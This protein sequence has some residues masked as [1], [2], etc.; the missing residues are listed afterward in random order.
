[1]GRFKRAGGF[2][3]AQREV[4]LEKEVNSNLEGKQSHTGVSEPEREVSCTGVKGGRELT[5][6]VYIRGWIG[7]TPVTFTA[8]TGASR[9]VVSSRV[10][11][12]LSIKEKPVLKW[13]VKLRG[14]GGSPIHESGVGE[15]NMKL[16]PVKVTCQAVVADID[17]EVLLGPDVWAGEKD[18]QADIFL[19]KSIIK[20]KG[21]EI[22]LLPDTKRLRKVT[23]E[24]EVA[25]P[26]LSEVMADDYVEREEIDDKGKEENFVFESTDGFVQRNQLVMAPTLVSVNT[27]G[28]CKVNVLKPFSTGVALRHDAEVG[29]AERTDCC[30]AVIANE[31][32]ECERYN[33]TMV[34][35]VQLN[36][37]E[38][39]SSITDLTVANAK[40]VPPHLKSVS[41]EF[42]VFKPEEQQSV[43]V[44][45]VPK[46]GIG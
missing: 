24:E 1:L 21:K 22:T 3:R 2:S 30:T 12:Q 16:G 9:T 29:K 37:A 17:D 27:A 36:S 34:R 26:G 7:E 33:I 25:I 31:E 8:D 20:L 4:L 45:L 43:I 15:F 42:V 19:S 41:E 14:A 44:G 39:D 23:A 32:N 10:Y 46:R 13:S 6:G 28:T 38:T 35:R 40:D 5:T 18:G 11:D